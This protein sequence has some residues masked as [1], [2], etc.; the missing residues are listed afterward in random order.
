M[1][2]LYIASIPFVAMV[3]A[4]LWF[5]HDAAYPSDGF[6]EYAFQTCITYCYAN[7]RPTRFP[8]D[9]ANCVQRCQRIYNKDR[10]DLTPPSKRN[11]NHEP[12][13]R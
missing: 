10:Y 8:A 5:P 3:L 7:F 1:S 4:L 6:D 9:H 12:R 11:Y 2:K 13:G